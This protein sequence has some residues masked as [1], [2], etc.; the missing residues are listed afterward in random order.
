VIIDKIEPENNST[1]PMPT[2]SK[3]R[4]TPI[5]LKI[6]SLL[7]ILNQLKAENFF[8]AEQAFY[9]NKVV[10]ENHLIFSVP[11]NKMTTRQ[12]HEVK[13][14]EKEKRILINSQYESI[15]FPSLLIYAMPLFPMIVGWNNLSQKKLIA[16]A[17]MIVATTLFISIFAYVSL[18]EDS[19]KIE[20][21]LVIRL[22]YLL[23]QKGYKMKL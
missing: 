23:R 12:I 13:Y 15:F 17:L 8:A 22:N 1:Y 21:E 10:D 3:N 20:R 11:R 5:D 6:F 7:D 16:L 18:I 9:L 14:E 4:T 19:K 2:L